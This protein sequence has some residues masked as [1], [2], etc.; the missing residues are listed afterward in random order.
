MAI[1]IGAIAAAAI[2][3]IGSLA[4]GDRANRQRREMAR[5]QMAFQER[6]S[7]TAYQRSVKDMKAAGI[8]PMLAYMQGGASSPGGAMP[9]VDDVISP[10]VSSAMQGMRMRA[11]LKLVKEQTDA[12]RQLNLKAQ[13]E[14]TES[15]SRGALLDQQ[16][17][18]VKS[19][20][21]SAGNIAELYRK[22][23]WLNA[24]RGLT[25]AVGG[26]KVPF[27]KGGRR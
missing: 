18:A 27:T 22:Y 21:V 24:V 5:E 23:P 17:F 12:Q 1:P 26:L 16:S 11:D 9:A 15:Y 8:N 10:A 3:A 7:S 14:T 20:N 4:G 2:P 13:A 6:M 19:A 25:D